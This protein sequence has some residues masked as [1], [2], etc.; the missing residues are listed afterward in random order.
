MEGSRKQISEWGQ[1]GMGESRNRRERIGMGGM[2][3]S[4]NKKNDKESE[5]D[6][7]MGP[8]QIGREPEQVEENRNQRNGGMGESPNKR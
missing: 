2:G 5:E 4:W 8:N 6:I 1:S 3:Q 7:R